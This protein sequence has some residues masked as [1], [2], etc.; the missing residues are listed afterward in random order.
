MK[1]RLKSN[2]LRLRLTQSEVQSLAAGILVQD[3]TQFSSSASLHYVIQSSP[4]AAGISADFRDQIVAVTVPEA[5]VRKW[6]TTDQISMEAE[7]QIAPECVLSLLIEKDFTC[8]NPRTPGEDADA[9]PNPA[10]EK[11]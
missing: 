8:L 11:H 5:M 10:A 7:H 3:R 6:A 1:L 4:S 9:F 2:S